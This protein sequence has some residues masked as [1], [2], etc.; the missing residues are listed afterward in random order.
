[1]LVLW[2]AFTA[3]AIEPAALV[4]AYEQV[5]APLAENR[6]DDARR[7]ATALAALPEAPAELPPAARMVAAAVD[8]EAARV[9][10]GEVSRVV[11]RELATVGAPDGTKVF[12]CPMAAGWG[13]WIQP[14][15]GIS[16]PY[17]GTAMPTCGEGTSLKSAAKAVEEGK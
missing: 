3:R 5:R 16:N 9:A 15:A 11:V 8:A 6:L 2:L 17:M 14:A 4:A 1:M 12:R 10:F 7:A 13:Y